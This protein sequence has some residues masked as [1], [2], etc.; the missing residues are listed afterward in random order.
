MAGR[1]GRG[2]A[3]AAAAAAAKAKAA[4]GS[5]RQARRGQARPRPAKPQDGRPRAPAQPRT[6]AR[7]HVWIPALGINRSVRWFPCDRARPPDN[8]MYRWGCAGSNNVYLMGHAYSVMKAAPRRVRPRPAPSRHE[9]L[10][11]R[12]A[13]AGCT[14]YAV[15]W[16]KITR[17]T[18]DA[19][20]AWAAQTV[21]VDDAPDV[22]RR[23][24]EYRLMVRLVEVDG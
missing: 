3:K 6:P 20:W 17:P 13:T 12:R 16:W 23:N 10:L 11:R 1:R 22:R 21:A 14:S 7:N 8:Y 15:K 2:A 9:G 19:A 4:A 18:T 5:R 24:S